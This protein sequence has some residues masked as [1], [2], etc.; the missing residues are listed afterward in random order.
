M[1]D[2]DGDDEGRNVFGLAA[3]EAEATDGTGDDGEHD[4]AGVDVILL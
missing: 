2:S 3:A 1:S 4:G